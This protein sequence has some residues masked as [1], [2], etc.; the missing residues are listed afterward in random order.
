M[1]NKNFLSRESLSLFNYIIIVRSKI[2]VKK[3]LKMPQHYHGCKD[4]KSAKNTF[5]TQFLTVPPSQAR[6]W[7]KGRA[8]STVRHTGA[9]SVPVCASES[10]SERLTTF[11]SVVCDGKK[12]AKVFIFK[13]KPGKWIKSSLHDIL[14]D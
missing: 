1:S 10:N 7:L 5:N 14:P 13:E 9:R 2:F 8:R 6:G 11:L 3:K 4:V 12:I